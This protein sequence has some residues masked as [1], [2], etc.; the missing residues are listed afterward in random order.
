[1]T[2][3]VKS[4]PSSSKWLKRLQRFVIFSGVLLIFAFWGIP[5]LV[6]SD[7]LRNRVVNES[8]AGLGV[9]AETE[10]ARFG[11][12]PPT[13][14]GGLRVV[15][16]DEQL[17]VS[18]DEVCIG[19]SCVQLAFHSD[20]LGHVELQNPS[21]TLNLNGSKQQDFSFNTLPTFTASLQDAEFT[22]RLA[23]VKE[24]VID[25]GGLN[26]SVRVD[27]DDN[28]A[29]V[30]VERGKIFDHQPLTSQMCAGIMHLID[31]TLVGVAHVNGSFSLDVERLRVPLDVTPDEQLQ[32]V[33]FEGVLHL[34][35]ITTTAKTPLLRRVLRVASDLYGKR[36][37]DVV[38]VVD[39]N[40]IHVRIRQ[41]RFHHDQLVLG[42]PEISPDLKIYSRG[43]VGFDETLELRLTIPEVLVAE[44]PANVNPKA[45][46]RFDVTGTVDEPIITRL[47]E[48]DK[49]QRSQDKNE[50]P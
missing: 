34:H 41:G 4:K 36:P 35:E 44:D 6:S 1:M 37:D 22:V 25:L 40:E 12:F 17:N 49:S 21:V 23:K 42:F 32:Q 8:V 28:G 27:R 20:H 13:K 7:L 48:D 3:H 10:S 2:D 5:F 39:D 26:I 19:Q 45:M 11:W 30:V 14:L 18:A 33:D 46:V 38:R 9:Q 50:Q 16:A 47:P 43:S 31:P 29:Y 15:S 24:P